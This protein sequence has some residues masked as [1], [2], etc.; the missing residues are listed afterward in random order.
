M[1]VFLFVCWMIVRVSKASLMNNGGNKVK[2]VSEEPKNTS[3]LL[4]YLAPFK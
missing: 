1:R 2:N 4:D 3:Q